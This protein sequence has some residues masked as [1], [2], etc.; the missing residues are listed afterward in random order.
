MPDATPYFMPAEW[1]PQE[2]VWL[3]W[4]CNKE[5]A[6]ETHQ[7]LQAKF[8]E[9]AAAISQFEKVRINAA[10]DWHKR[11]QQSI[12]DQEADMA[13]VELHEHPTN[14]VWCR[15][16]GPIFVKHADTGD[17]AVTDW[18]FNAWGGKFP[19]WDL[20]NQV[21]ER[22]SKVLSLPR[23]ASEMILEGGSIEVNGAGVLLTTEAV[24]LNKN[25]NPDWSK[26]EIE[27]EIKKLLGVGSIFWLRSGIEGDDTDGHIDDITR[28]IQEDVVLTMV[29]KRENDPN[30][31]ILEENKERLQ[32]LRTTGG[33]RVEILTLPMPAPL[34]P[35]SGWRL[36]RLPASYANFLIL[37]DAVLVPIFNQRKRDLNAL[38]FIGECFPGREIVGIECSDLVF[39]GGALHCISQQ[40]PSAG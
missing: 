38:G 31:R 20:D 26:Q 33:R 34:T 4:P 21:P 14:D 5:S 25:R 16:H 39:E 24:L 11:I 22:V 35:S 3:S 10:G 27:A 30:H 40:Q 37:N 1:S 6:P 13:N 28:F 9:I 15:D 17:L 36:E 23:F 12:A 2:A 32:D 18:K 29:E 7:V 19:P 8:G